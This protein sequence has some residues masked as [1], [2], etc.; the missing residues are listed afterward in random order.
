M[1]GRLP[2]RSWRFRR[3]CFP[4]TRLS[5]PRGR[6]AFSLDN[7]NNV[8]YKLPSHEAA[9]PLRENRSGSFQSVVGCLPIHKM[10]LWYASREVFFTETHT[11][12]TFGGVAQLVRAH[13]SYPCCP[14]FKSLR[15]HQIPPLFPE[16][17]GFCFGPIFSSNNCCR[18]ASSRGFRGVF[19]RGC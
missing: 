16:K 14:G 10:P 11:E 2:A 15:R 8:L 5:P 7:G 13:G 9:N 12:M 3:G 19:R 18:P 17:R 4:N 6:F 1:P